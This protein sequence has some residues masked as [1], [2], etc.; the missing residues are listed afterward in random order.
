MSSSINKEIDCLIRRCFPI[1]GT[2]KV[3]VDAVKRAGKKTILLAKEPMSHFP[4]ADGVSP[5][6]AAA[7]KKTGPQS[8]RIVFAARQL[9]HLAAKAKEL[10][11]LLLAPPR[12]NRTGP[13]STP[14]WKGSPRPATIPTGAWE[15]IR[16]A[17]RTLSPEKTLGL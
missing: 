3:V 10:S 1:I 7:Q 5:W 16:P 8:C 9:G 15:Y 13:R 11:P 17:A 6:S 12:Q 14:R 4:A 2:S